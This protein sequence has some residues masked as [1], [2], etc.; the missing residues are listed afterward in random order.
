MTEVLGKSQ[1]LRKKTDALLLSME[2]LRQSLAAD[3]P[4]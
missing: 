4:G 1:P 2:R 3:V